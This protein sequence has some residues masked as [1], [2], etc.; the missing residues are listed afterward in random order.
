MSKVLE[1]IKHTRS[2]HHCS[3][4]GKTIKQGSE[5]VA[6]VIADSL[7]KFISYFCGIDCFNEFEVTILTEKK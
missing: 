4:C 3:Q 5:A 7:G 2:R 6:L 1:I